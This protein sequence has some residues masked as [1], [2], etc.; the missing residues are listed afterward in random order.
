MVSIVLVNWNSG[1][2][3]E[4]CVR[5][6]LH[7]AADCSIIIVDNASTDGSLDC[8]KHNDHISVIRN[9]RNLGFAAACNIGWKAGTGEEVLFL[10]PDTEA[11]P[12]SIPSLQRAFTPDASVWAVGGRLVNPSGH[13]ED[14]LRPFPSLWTL[15]GDM[16]FVDEIA[17]T[18][19]RRAGRF[20]ASP[21]P[22]EIDQPAAACLMVSRKALEKTNGFDE[23]FYPAW[24]EDVDLCRRIWDLGGRILYQPAAKFLH[25]G[26]YSARRMAYEKFLEFFYGNQIQYFRKHH[27]RQAAASAQKLVLCGLLLRS[28]L[29]LAHP[30]APN[31]S[32]LNSARSFWN[33][34]KNLLRSG[35][36]KP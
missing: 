26:G 25:H 36:L 27:G 7:H 13:S 8:H 15:A 12:D 9:D 14:Y 10:N 5:S 29:S 34:L 23:A 19:R 4:N 32:R 35:R 18:K 22:L 16:L 30:L 20:D 17:G 6:L 1:S 28:A 2:H 31:E 33:A 11:F 24:F 21:V 3:L